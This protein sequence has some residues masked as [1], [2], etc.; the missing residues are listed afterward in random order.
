M[1]I[2]A[3][4]RGLVLT[5]VLVAAARGAR[6]G[7]NPVTA[8]ASDSTPPRGR[9]PVGE[10]Q[11][12][13]LTLGGQWHFRH[14]GSD[15]WRSVSLPHDWNARETRTNRS[16]VG[17]YR[18]NFTLP[19]APRG[20]RWIV[21]FE[22]AGHH[23]TVYLNGREIARH[24]GGYLPFEA[25]M[26]GL[27][28]GANQ[29]TVRVSSRRARSDL[30]HWRPARFN[31]YG[32]GMWWNFG[33]I[34]REVSVRPVGN[35]DIVRA[36]ALPQQDCAGC[37]AHVEVRTLVHN[38]TGQVR[39][40]RLGMSVEGRR[41][42]LPTQ[43]VGPGRRQELVG[44]FTIARP[45]QWD[46][47][48]GQM[49]RLDVDVDEE[50]SAP[51]AAGPLVRRARS[52]EFAPARYRTYF[53]VRHLRKTAD[54]RVLLNGRR[55]RLRG[56]SVHEDSP[57]VGSAWRAPQRAALLSWIDDIGANVVRAHY[58]LHP[59]LME[60]L[61]R[62]GILVWVQ[63][64]VNQVQNDQMA[65]AQVRRSALAANAATVIRD[66]GHPSV[67]A[68]SIA[69]ELPVPI[70]QAQIDYTRA[71]AAQVRALDPTRLVAIDRVARN[72]APDDGHPVFRAVDA[73]GANEYFG[74]YRGA[75]PPHPP[76]GT[77]DLAG[78]LDTLHRKQPHAALFLTEFGAEANR[79]GSAAR[80][81]T[82]AFQAGYLADHL[83]IA[84]RHPYV[85]GAMVWNLRDF[86][87]YPGWN[88]GN[89][90][91]DPPYNTKGLIGTDGRPKPAYF[92]V[93]S[94]FQSGP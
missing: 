32:N 74:W 14:A 7:A 48:R 34:H 43:A 25:Q 73:I 49:Y 2:V 89:P 78:Y 19:R 45:R 8:P 20:T 26:K 27:R 75:L 23:S 77:G 39:R 58:P 5:T 29:L 79:R 35:L 4:E 1:I 28:R 85:S 13:R 80:K 52:D 54:G 10:G 9:P 62:R 67:L 92:Q 33:G 21:R 88:G 6:A 84:A 17:I 86:R 82:Y 40:A 61:D 38:L 31:G 18:R 71:A 47:R 42:V 68:F 37:P 69:N 44:R 46:I 66:R 53:G 93:R 76:A 64:P 91:P 81:G 87:V 15:R 83:R 50:P 65:R 22:G 63:A 41:V 11:P 90:R 16:G 60:A 70:A 36:Q 24:A 12:G 51:R 59:A 72:H 56:I 57:V 3:V 30:T 55:L 94:L